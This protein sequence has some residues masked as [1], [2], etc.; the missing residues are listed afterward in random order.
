M[1]IRLPAR[2]PRQEI[3]A[4]IAGSGLGIADELNLLRKEIAQAEDTFN[5]RTRRK[6]L[7]G[8][9][10]EVFQTPDA[11]DPVPAR[12]DPVAAGLVP[13]E[14]LDVSPQQLGLSQ[15]AQNAIIPSSMHWTDFEEA[16]ARMLA[17]YG[18]RGGRS[19][20]LRN[21][22]AADLRKKQAK[23]DA[24]AAAHMRARKKYVDTNMAFKQGRLQFSNR[25]L[26]QDYAHFSTDAAH[27]FV[28]EATDAVLHG[29]LHGDGSAIRPLSSGELDLGQLGSGVGQAAALEMNVAR[30]S[31]RSIEQASALELRVM[32]EDLD[33]MY[34]A[35]AD[36]EQA[37][38]PAAGASKIAWRRRKQDARADG[39]ARAKAKRKREQ[40][41]K[42]ARK[43]AER[44][45][46]AAA[47]SAMD[48]GTGP[49]SLAQLRERRRAAAEG[50]APSATALFAAA[51]AA[52]AAAM[53]KT[54]PPPEED[55]SPYFRGRKSKSLRPAR[56]PPLPLDQPKPTF[57]SLKLPSLPKPYHGKPSKRY[58]EKEQQQQQAAIA[59][60]APSK[61]ATRSSRPPVAV[62]P[63]TGPLGPGGG[64]MY[65]LG[66]AG[67]DAAHAAAA[68]RYGPDGRPRDPRK[69]H[70]RVAPLSWQEHAGAAS[71]AMSLEEEA[72][73]HR[74]QADAEEAAA[75]HYR[76]QQEAVKRKAAD[77]AGFV[78][79]V[80]RWGRPDGAVLLCGRPGRLYDLRLAASARALQAWWRRWAAIWAARKQTGALRLQ[81]LRR[82]QLSRRE[83]A[84]LKHVEG[85]LRKHL[86]I[87]VMRDKWAAVQKW[88]NLV[89]QVKQLRALYVRMLVSDT[90]RRFCM[91]REWYA[92]EKGE[93]HRRFI[94]CAALL[95]N[96]RLGRVFDAWQ[97][98]SWRRSQRRRYLCH[99]LA[100]MTYVPVV[101]AAIDG[102]LARRHAAA[103]VLQTCERGR[104]QRVE[105]LRQRAAARLLQRVARGHADR[106]VVAAMV[107]AKLLKLRRE[108]RAR[109]QREFVERQRLARAA[110]ERR[111][112]AEDERLQV[113]LR[114]ARAR[115]DAALAAPEGQ[116]D[117]RRRAKPLVPEPEWKRKARAKAQG[118]MGMLRRRRPA[119]AKV[120]PL[121][122]ERRQIVA[123]ANGGK[124]EAAEAEKVEAEEDKATTPLRTPR[125]GPQ[126]QNIEE[127]M[128]LV[129]KSDREAAYRKAWEKAL[130]R[131]RKR[132][133][134][135]YCCRNPDCLMGFGTVEDLK[136]HLLS[137][138]I[139]GPALP[140]EK[141]NKD[142]KTGARDASRQYP[143][144]LGRVGVPWLELLEE[145]IQFYQSPTRA[146]QEF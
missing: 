141:D 43:Q 44:A 127:A 120:D 96:R 32:A 125:A 142:K 76:E 88:K 65:I 4:A 87:I 101:D 116:A 124:L 123:E 103:N 109:L 45:A 18:R 40:A 130:H 133:P 6:A 118:L 14:I 139:S 145:E 11:V 135:V 13:R 117:L 73:W 137:T 15:S 3:N 102:V 144:C 7:Y 48:V 138:G 24:R 146:L 64:L 58:R 12:I 21:T 53:A 39:R 113:A 86:N 131:F 31:L 90:R 84:R 112:R 55:T 71:A 62:V 68:P 85:T 60:S 78:S 129:E 57:H 92:R 35:E 72:A 108:A 59:G 50:P 54:E 52:A 74:A 10:V 16:S 33:V 93:R 128:A 105:F 47:A 94:R 81:C 29:V 30:A 89:K 106:A 91:W 34:G 121:L 75:I 49:I 97:R 98:W 143:P 1:S 20:P 79:L 41:R 26:H 132:R 136:E 8:T 28:T 9:R 122:L 27:D 22:N 46:L 51:N 100:A 66:T 115:L 140:G 95:L 70:F 69:R 2:R 119:A 111:A 114:K 104:V 83:A 56:V 23:E 38:S 36:A 134:P 63:V 99:K 5:E 77:T 25:S 67:D 80:K 107:R 17:K 110:E 61:I 19:R 37:L 126:P 42:A 82:G